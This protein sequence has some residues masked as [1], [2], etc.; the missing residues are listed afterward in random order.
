[1]PT[2]RIIGP[3]RA[4]GA[5]RGALAASGWTD[6]ELLG[7]SD[8]IRSAARGTDVVA[9][10]TPD[11]AIAAVAASIEPG[12]AV[13]LHLAGSLG[14]DALEPHARRAAMHPLMSLPTAEHGA[15]RLRSGGWFAVAG[16]PLAAS[17]VSDLGGRSF[18]V[19]D[20][21]RA[22]YHAAACVASNHVVALLGQVERLAASVG[23]PLEAYLDLTASSVSNV[24]LLGAHDA[25]TGP[26]ARGDDATIER[27]R[28]ALPPH[29]LD[30]YDSLVR[31]ARELAR[32]QGAA[33]LVDGA[34]EAERP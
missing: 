11:A 2:A 8:D 31:A 21:D 4:G 23:V 33:G 13:V 3:G 18:E 32:G 19:L 17:M 5:L 30:L 9:I 15:E 29:E 12:D 1:M 14:L 24:G 22:V 27:H 20:A 16:D 10:A 25:L 28:A 6:L 26:A 7:R 34:A